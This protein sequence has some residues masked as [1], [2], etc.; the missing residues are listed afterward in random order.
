MK[1]KKFL[2]AILLSVF[3]A[4]ILCAPAK[5]T[6]SPAILR[7]ALDAARPGILDP[8]FAA[9]T[10]TR[11]MADMVFNGLLRYKPGRAPLIEPDLAESIPEPKIVDGKQVWIFK[12][13]KGV[14]F[15]PGPRTKAYELTA[16]DVVYSLEKSA[17]PKHSAYSGEYIGMTFEKKDDYTIRI[18]LDKPLS[19]FLFFPKVSDYAG[20]FIVSKKAIE[21]MG[22]EAFKSNPVGTGPFVFESYT[23]GKKVRLVANERYF[24]GRPLLDA[25]DVLYMPDIDNRERGLKAGELDI[26]RGL[27][28]IE[29][30]EKIKQERDIVVDTHGVGEVVTIHFN[31]MVKPLNDIRIRKAIAYT[32]DRNVFLSYL[33]K[34]VAQN[35]YSIVPPQFLPGGLTKEEVGRLGLDYALNLDKARQLLAE[36]GYPE[37]FSLEVMTSEMTVYRKNYENMRDQLA[38]AGINLK[39]KVVNH[40]AMHKLI[41]KDINPI[42]LYSAWRPNADVYLTRFFHSNSIVVTGAKPDTNFSHYDKIDKL[43]ESARFETNP[44]RQ[45]ELWK[46]AQINILEDMAAYPLHYKNFV[47]VRRSCV[48]YGHELVSSMALYPQI[49]EKTRIVQNKQ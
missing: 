9:A 27:P 11:I 12:L 15:H 46:Q 8:H 49:T 31:T 32:L 40:S 22:D 18:I 44:G 48:D 10:Q 30:I 24:R 42:V 7:L 35:V 3:V 39:I 20:G 17:D 29:W 26:I 47:R 37:G 14:M 33:G 43:I 38:R 36:A 41:R 5:A 23:P 28:Q 1:C 6:D 34:H 19:S 21:A 45:V 13:R 25:V 16:D 4:G 2:L